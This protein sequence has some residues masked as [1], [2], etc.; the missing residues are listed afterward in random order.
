MLFRSV[1]SILAR[2]AE[3]PEVVALDTFLKLAASNQTFKT[4]Y[5]DSRPEGEQWINAVP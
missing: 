1:I 3:Q 5:K 2:L 4:R